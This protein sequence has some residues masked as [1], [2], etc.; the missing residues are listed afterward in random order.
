MAKW[1]KKKKQVTPIG[2]LQ[3]THFQYKDTQRLKVNLW[4][5]IFHANKNKKSWGSYTYIRQNRL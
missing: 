3:E 2:C 4:E 1:I 5:K